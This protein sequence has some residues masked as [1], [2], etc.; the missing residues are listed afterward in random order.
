MS[1]AVSYWDPLCT[2]VAQ[3]RCWVR[4]AYRSRGE[5]L[6]GRW[7]QL[8]KMPTNT[9]LEGSG[10]PVPLA[11]VEWVE[12]STK[13]IFGGIAGRPLRMVEI[14]DDVLS[15][16]RE[17]GVTWDLREGTWSVEDVFD[18]EPVQIVRVLNPFGPTPASRPGPDRSD[19]R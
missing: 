11:D 3:L 6:T 19:P 12:L 16:V 10:G 14:K 8:L 2:L 9:Y 18:D 15:V 4:L 13:R 1:D 5:T 17:A 7:G